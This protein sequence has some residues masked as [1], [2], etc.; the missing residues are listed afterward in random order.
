M[1]KQNLQGE[2][3]GMAAMEKLV[4]KVSVKQQVKKFCFPKM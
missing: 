3:R 2:R 1:L 4:I